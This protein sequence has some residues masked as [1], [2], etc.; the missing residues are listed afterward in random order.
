M[1]YKIPPYRKR[2]R[3]EF[4]QVL[5]RGFRIFSPDS[6]ADRERKRKAKER[7]YLKRFKEKKRRRDWHDFYKSL[8]WAR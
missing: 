6:E 1:V 7:K 4:K 8:E 3:S 2:V 5:R